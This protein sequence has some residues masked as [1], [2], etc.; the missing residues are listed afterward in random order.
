MLHEAPV[1]ARKVVD[2]LTRLQAELLSNP[3]PIDP[4][5]LD[6]G[7]DVMQQALDSAQRLQTVLEQTDR[8]VKDLK[9]VPGR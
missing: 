5:Q 4:R 1:R 3:G 9:S 2:D 6:R 8:R 7:R